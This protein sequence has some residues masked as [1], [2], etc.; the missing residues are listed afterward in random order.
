MVR[1]TVRKRDLLQPK[2]VRSQIQSQMFI[3][4]AA[5]LLV[6][7]LLL[8]GYK[9]IS[10]FKDK[11]RKI[12]VVE[13]ESAIKSGVDFVAGEYGTVKKT[14]I[15]VP[16]D[17]DMICFLDLTRRDELLQTSVADFP[18]IQESLE[19]FVQKNVFLMSKNK[20][21]DLL[22]V[23]PLCFSSPYYKC[24]ETPKQLLKIL[25]KGR[26][27]CAD[28][29]QPIPLV[30][31]NNLKNITKYHT[32][33]V[34]IIEDNSNWQS[35]ARLVPLALWNRRGT[36]SQNAY[37]VY[38]QNGQQP[39]DQYLVE[40]LL[41]KHNSSELRFF[42]TVPNSIVGNP[43]ISYEAFTEDNYFN[44]WE[45]LVDIVVMNSSNQEGALVGSLFAAYIAAPLIFVDSTNLATYMEYL[46][47]AR[48]YV[49]DSIE[50]QVRDYL[51]ANSAEIVDY[52]SID[53]RTDSEINPYVRL[54]SNI[55][56]SIYIP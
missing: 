27:G 21:T 43:N 53:I 17:T 8:F 14:E 25:I 11:M 7:L 18:E 23:G 42:S 22:Y 47:G 44:Y 33:P 40:Y 16:E 51:A 32:N 52:N 26:Q 55:T 39:Q 48:A 19:G 31:L 49:I 36:I 34:F 45:F 10:G 6:I 1:K 24:L 38:Y 35:I 4:I 50:P 41:A 54:L 46:S 12:S 9:T 37:Y 20:V 3:Y 56:P 28:I 29:I 2:G 5:A 13:V 15:K 30:R